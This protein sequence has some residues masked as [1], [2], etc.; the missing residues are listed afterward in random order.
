MNV[1][2]SDDERSL[3]ESWVTDGLLRGFVDYGTTDRR[4]EAVNGFLAEIAVEH[5]AL[6]VPLA[7][8]AARGTGPDGG[9]DVRHS[10]VTLQ[11]K[12]TRHAHGALICRPDLPL[13]ADVLALVVP[14]TDGWS[15]VR[16][17]GWQARD[18]FVHEAERRSFGHNAV[19]ALDQAD[20]RPFPEL[21]AHLRPGWRPHV[22]PYGTQ[23]EVGL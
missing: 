7:M 10:D 11:V 5:H 15:H 2:F 21:V 16:V 8:L 6:G 23:L 19:Q 9:I 22:W 14:A 12:W 1:R 18:V 17:A 13:R 3:A 20:L 4:T